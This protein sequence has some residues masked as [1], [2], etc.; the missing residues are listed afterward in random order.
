[1]QL[2][3]KDVALAML[4]HL[5]KIAEVQINDADRPKDGNY[6][7]G[8]FGRDFG[9]L[10]GKRLM[11][12]A[13][14]RSQWKNLVEVTELAEELAVLAKRLRLDFD[15]EATGSGH[16]G[17]SPGCSSRG[18]RPSCWPRCGRS[19]ER[20]G[21]HLGRPRRSTCAEVLSSTTPGTVLG[22]RG[23]RCPPRPAGY[24]QLPDAGAA[25]ELQWPGSRA[26]PPGADAAGER[27]DEILLD[28]LGLDGAEVGR[29][30]DDGVVAGP[31]RS[32]YNTAVD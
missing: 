21:V 22:R 4:G 12:V 28:L 15:K 16:D 13:L 24:R 30:H 20:S 29:L 6:L 19:F 31:E 25:A 7:Y 14:T 1:M 10:D 18:S 3:L 2:A 5:G 32:A 9:T 27:T 8:A 11:V 23:C 26:R 17:R